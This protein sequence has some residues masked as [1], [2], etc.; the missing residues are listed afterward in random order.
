[1][2]EQRRYRE[3]V[4]DAADYGRLR[5]SSHIAQ[6]DPAVVP[7][8]DERDH[9]DDY[10]ADQKKKREPLHSDQAVALE[11]LIGY[12]RCS[13][14]HGRGVVRDRGLLGRRHF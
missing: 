14:P 9:E 10:R 13:K 11:R 5:C 3:P 2:A 4:C 6:P 1:M 7:L 12:R 8:H